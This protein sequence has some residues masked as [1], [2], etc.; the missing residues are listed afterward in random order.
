M[1][2]ARPRDLAISKAEF[3]ANGLPEILRAKYKLRILWNLQHGYVRFGEI[4]KGLSL[5]DADTNTI[6][7]RVLSRELKSLAGSG[8]VQRR[9][10]NVIPPRVEYRLTA[11]GRSLLPVITKILDWGARHPARLFPCLGDQRR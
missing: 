1:R 6:A 4:R 10:Y 5:G 8:L 3:P 7:P 9:A 2:S 11:L